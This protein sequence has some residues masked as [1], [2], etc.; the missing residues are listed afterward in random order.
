MCGHWAGAHCSS[1]IRKSTVS[2]LPADVVMTAKKVVWNGIN[3]ETT[4]AGH[5][6]VSLNRLMMKEFQ[7]PNPPPPRAKCDLC[8]MDSF[9]VL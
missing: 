1:R 6:R 2:G 3:Q 4:V 9:F 8:S 5:K 7:S